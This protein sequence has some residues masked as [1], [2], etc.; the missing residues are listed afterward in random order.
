MGSCFIIYPNPQGETSGPKK[1][2]LPRD[3]SNPQA[4]EGSLHLRF[5]T[6]SF[7]LCSCGCKLATGS[8][9]ALALPSSRAHPRGGGSGSHTTPASPTPSW[10]TGRAQ[11]HMARLPVPGCAGLP[12]APGVIFLESL[13]APPGRALLT[14]VFFI[15]KG[16]AAIQPRQRC[17]DSV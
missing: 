10:L 13:R 5:A 2:S 12:G 16:S 11:P 4:E 7:K 8:L 6:D 3:N 15:R 1:T 9:S 14:C 17:G